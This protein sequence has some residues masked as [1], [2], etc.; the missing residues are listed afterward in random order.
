MHSREEREK[1]YRDSAQVLNELIEAR[2]E[3]VREH[4]DCGGEPLCIGPAPMIR[5]GVAC[6]LDQG[7]ATSLVLVAVGEMS[8]QRAEIER[9]TGSLEA[10]R[11]MTNDVARAHESAMERAAKAE[12][13]QQ[14][15]L[16][17]IDDL[18]HQVGSLTAEVTL[19]EESADYLGPT[20]LVEPTQAD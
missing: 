4:P 14:V 13:E 2:E 6:S 3:H 12:E 11:G 8:R 9:L 10:Q 1:E 18:E 7:F 20:A 5:L 19:W 16:G 17:R 15:L